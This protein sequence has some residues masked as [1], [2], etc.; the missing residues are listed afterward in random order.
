MSSFFTRAEWGF[1]RVMPYKAYLVIDFLGGVLAFDAPWLL[2]FSHND[3]AC[4]AFLAFGITGMLAGLCSR[5]DEMPPQQASG[6]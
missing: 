3:R 5:P 2:G 4:K 1:A 6:A